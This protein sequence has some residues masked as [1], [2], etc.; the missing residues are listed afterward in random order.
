MTPNIKTV[1]HFHSL[2]I[3]TCLY[4][5]AA[6]ILT[7]IFRYQ[8]NPDGISYIA[9]A[10]K[11]AAGDFANA[12]N[13]LWSPLFSLL[14]APFIKL[15]FDP[16][17]TAK[18]FNFVF[19]YIIVITVYGL[20]K[21]LKFDPI[22]TTLVI[23]CC[24]A[25]SLSYAALWITPDLLSVMFIFFY[26]YIISDT[27]YDTKTKPAICCGLVGALAYLSKGYMFTF[28]AMHFFIISV[29]KFASAS[30]PDH[31]KK[32]VI[33]LLAGTITFVLICTPWAALL[34][35]KYDHFTL[36]TAGKF[37]LGLVAPDYT[38]R[39]Q[40]KDGFFA[41]P[42]P[43]AVS[44]MEDPVD[45]GMP[46]WSPFD[47]SEDFDYFLRHNLKKNIMQIFRHLNKW[48]PLSSIIVA[49]AILLFFY[50]VKTSTD[51][52]RTALILLAGFLLFPAGYI[53]VTTAFDRYFIAMYFLL[54]LLTGFVFDI[55]LKKF[56]IPKPAAVL[57]YCV[58]A[59]PFA[60]NSTKTIRQYDITLC[61]NAHTIGTAIKQHIGPSPKIASDTK[62]VPTYFITYHAGGHFYGI[63][64]A[65]IS[66][67]DL[68]GELNKY[69]IEYYLVWDEKGLPTGDFA[70]LKTLDIPGLTAP[71]VYQNTLDS[72]K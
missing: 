21:K 41:P 25:I 52:S 26:F 2:I 7:I 9:I 61:N 51:T 16:Q 68:S 23:I 45:I 47:S 35:H 38:G 22:S 6:I 29:I 36:T 54:A 46:D 59:L 64:K 65:G 24:T 48:S 34:T 63:P 71:L 11:Y 30:A 39:P 57:L 70:S 58:L 4:I 18:C 27:A 28:F 31:K 5:P 10:Q 37:N 17:L 33:N 15:G 12:V 14:M 32:I 13:G 44:V 42:N 3:L 62:Y 43:T 66:P 53:L 55:I 69:G 72:D 60:W 8:I 1:Q 56:S 50:P 40:L 20:S 49:A 67:A 19:G